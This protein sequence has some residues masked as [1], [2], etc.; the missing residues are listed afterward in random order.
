MLQYFENKQG[1][2]EY[3]IIA[4]LHQNDP[5]GNFILIGIKE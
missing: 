3:D 1:S 5:D 4:Y 2:D